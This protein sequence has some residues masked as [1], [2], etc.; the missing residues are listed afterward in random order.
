MQYTFCSNSQHL[1]M[2]NISLRTPKSPS[3]FFHSFHHPGSSNHG[4]WTKDSTTGP[5][6]PT[7]GKHSRGGSWFFHRKVE[8]NAVIF[9]CFFF[10]R[11]EKLGGGG[12]WQGKTGSISRFPLNS[13]FKPDVETKAREV[14]MQWTGRGLSQ[15]VQ[16]QSQIVVVSLDI[17]YTITRPDLLHGSPIHL[18]LANW[19]KMSL[20][21]HSHVRSWT[22]APHPLHS[23]TSAYSEK[24]Q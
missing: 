10:L 7:R 16:S 9:L 19:N 3:P 20:A 12:G 13:F 24:I 17:Q 23:Q 18:S 1:N 8:K 11:G 2:R 5:R 21:S 22:I 15:A 6:T 4:F 14:W